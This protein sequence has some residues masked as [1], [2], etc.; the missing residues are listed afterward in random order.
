MTFKLC[1]DTRLPFQKK[2]SGGNM[3][4]RMKEE[5]TGG[6]KNK[7]SSYRNSTHEK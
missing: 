5:E 1:S 6:K 2:N 7:A 3:E 4:D